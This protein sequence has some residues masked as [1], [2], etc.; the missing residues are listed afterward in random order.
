VFSRHFHIATILAHTFFCVLHIFWTVERPY[1]IPVSKWGS[2]FFV[3]PPVAGTFLLFV[4]SSWTTFIYAICVQ[5]VGV[6]L[7][8]LHH[9]A[10][11]NNWCEFAESKIDAKTSFVNLDKE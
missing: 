7:Y 6:I 11:A 4:C 8:K 3:V 9:I 5:L 10:L 1:R 2:I